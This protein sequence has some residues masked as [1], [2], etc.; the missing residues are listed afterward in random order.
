VEK[1]RIMHYIRTQWVCHLMV[2][3]VTGTSLHISNITTDGFLMLLQKMN[4]RNSRIS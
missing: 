1:L 2:R 3:I 4:C